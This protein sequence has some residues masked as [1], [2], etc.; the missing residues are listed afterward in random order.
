MLDGSCA[1]GLFAPAVSGWGRVVGWMF[2]KKERWRG[3]G[4]PP[5]S[6]CGYGRALVVHSPALQSGQL[7]G[8]QARAPVGHSPPAGGMGPPRAGVAAVT[9]IR[10]VKVNLPSANPVL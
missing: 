7:T 4:P 10:S 8:A 3:L 5:L 6:G 1:A 9:E 2:S